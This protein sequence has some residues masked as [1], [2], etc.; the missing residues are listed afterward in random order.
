MQQT[1]SNSKSE[2]AAFFRFTLPLLARTM[3]A[4]SCAL[5]T[6]LSS[7]DQIGKLIGEVTASS[8][9]LLVHNFGFVILAK[10]ALALGFG[11]GTLA[12]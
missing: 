4:S 5:W 2:T 3:V 11:L 7:L 10:I 1:I 8:G 9:T 6:M 12:F